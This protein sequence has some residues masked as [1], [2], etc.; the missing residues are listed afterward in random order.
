MQNYRDPCEE[1]TVRRYKK[2]KGHSAQIR[3]SLAISKCNLNTTAP[4]KQKGA[5]SRTDA[6]T[7]K[8]T[9]YKNE[10]LTCNKN[11]QK[12]SQEYLT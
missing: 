1:K 9:L 4:R 2:G 11:Y 6:E 3:R 7:K 10:E 12:L 8:H 5:L